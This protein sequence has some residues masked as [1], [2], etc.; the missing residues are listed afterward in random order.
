MNALRLLPHGGHLGGSKRRN[1]KKKKKKK[2]DCVMTLCCGRERGALSASKMICIP[3]LF[4]FKVR[5]KTFY[6]EEEEEDDEGEI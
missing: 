3:V 1:K 6:D 5:S 2:P 4:S